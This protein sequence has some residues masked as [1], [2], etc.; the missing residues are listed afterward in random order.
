MQS[1]GRAL[2]IKGGLLTHKG[3]IMN[4]FFF[5]T[6]P[7]HAHRRPCPAV[8]VR[9]FLEHLEDRCLPSADM[10]PV[11]AAANPSPSAVNAIASLPHDQIHMLQDQFQQQT[12]Q[13]IIRLEVEQIVLGVLQQFASQA[14][15]FQPVIA[16]LTND[17]P[18]QQATVQTLQNQTNLLNQLDDVQDQSIILNGMIQNAAAL[19]PVFQQLGNQQAVNAL[20]NTI[21]TDQAAVQALQPQIMAAE[22]EVAAFV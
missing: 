14:P 22:V 18:M 12:T 6:G 10:M 9:P 20:K 5:A 13:A 7:K 3:D 4:L 19:I 16:F 11:S 21:A 8:S 15:Q 17:I 2:V 1:A